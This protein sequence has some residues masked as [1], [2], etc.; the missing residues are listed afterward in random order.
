MLKT[1]V[2]VKVLVRSAG[3]VSRKRFLLEVQMASKVRHP[4]IVYLP[5]TA[6]CPTADRIWSA[7]PLSGPTLAEVLRTGPLPP[8]GPTASPCRSPAADGA[9]PGSSTAIQ[10]SNIFP[11]RA[12]PPS[13]RDFVKIVDL[14]VAKDNLGTVLTRLRRKKGDRDGFSA[15]RAAARSRG[16]SRASLAQRA[17][18]ALMRRSAPRSTWRQSRS[19][20]ARMPMRA[21]IVRLG[22]ILYRMLTGLLPFMAETRPR[23]S[24]GCTS[25]PTSCPASAPSELTISDANR[26]VKLRCLA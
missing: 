12:M 26:S 17:D 8:F 25:R 5:T 3:E 10:A 19:T 1:K 24:C 7:N 13:G 16:T 11:C 22:R 20:G 2:A 6:C 15:T 14:G 23:R 18:S 21:R 9:R 4:N